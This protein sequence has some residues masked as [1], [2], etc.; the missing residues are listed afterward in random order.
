MKKSLQISLLSL[1][2]LAVGVLFTQ[3]SVTDK[4][5]QYQPRQFDQRTSSGGF[6]YLHSVKANQVTGTID[7]VDV[8]A[9]QNHS[10]LS[11][12]KKGALGLQWSAR[13]PSNIGGR[14]RALLFDKDDA[15]TMFL[16]GVSGGI[17]RSKTGGSSW[18]P[19]HD[20]STN[21]GVTAIAQTSDGTLYYGTGEGMFAGA[22]GAT[23]T[24]TGFV[25]GGIFKSTDGGDTWAAVT[26]TTPTSITTNAEWAS[27][28]TIL[29]HE[30]DANTM[31]VGTN[32][33]I[34]YTT[35]G[36]TSWTNPITVPGGSA[37]ITD[38]HM[39]SQN[40]IW[41]SV[42][43]R[44]FY[45][46]N[47]VTFT[48]I[49]KASAGPTDLPRGQNRVRVETAPTDPNYVYALL[50]GNNGGLDR[51]FKSSDKGA[52]WSVIGQSS[53][54]WDPFQAFNGLVLSGNGQGNYDLAMRVD[55]TNK[56][57]LIIGGIDLWD[58]TSNGSWNV[59]SQWSATPG[60]PWYVHADNHNIYYHPTKTNEFFVVNDGGLFKTSDNGISFVPMNLEFNTMQFYGIGVGADRT[61]IG[62]AQDNGTNINDGTGNNVG[63]AYEIQGGDGGRAAISWLN[64]EVYFAYVNQDLTRTQN[65]ADSWQR[66]GDWFDADMLSSSL[67]WNAPFR[68][69][70]NTSDLNSA[71]S[72]NFIA[73]P[74]LKSLGF[75]NGTIDSFY[76]EMGRPQEAAVFDASSFVVYAGGDTI[77]SDA[78]GNLSGDGTGMFNATTGVFYVIFD[79]APVA[80][81][82]AICN[83]SYASGSDIT[84]SSKIN[85]LPYNYTLMTPLLTGDSVKAQDPVQ[86]FY[87]VCVGG[88]VWMTR[89]ALDFSETPEWW[90]VANIPG[91]TVASIQI[92]DDGDVIYVGTTS[93][94]VI[95]VTNV[96]QAR[97]FETADVTSGTAVTA[98]KNTVVAGNRFVASISAD[99]NDANKVVVTLGNYGN[100]SYVYYSSNAASANPSYASKQGSPT[101]GLLKAPVY[102]SVIHKGDSKKVI[103]GTEFGIYTTDDITAALPI[104]TEENDGFANAPV[105][106][107]VQYR[108]NRSSDTSSTIK[109]GDI[110]IGSHGR[111]WYVSTS[112][113][114]DRP[115]SNEENVIEDKVVRDA[116]KMYPNPAKDFTNVDVTLSGKGDVKASVLDM[117][118]RI[119]KRVSLKGLPQGDHKIRVDLTG[120][121]NGTYV[122]SV[123][124]NG[125]VKNG[126][127]IVNK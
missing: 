80:E 1:S 103:L 58:Y 23:L 87:V 55:K 39:D 28:S 77:R 95:S 31:W 91:Q 62:G 70:E 56:D 113:Q 61:L 43:S 51:V 82:I 57:R 71:D 108:T 107:L 96:S 22:A 12:N 69:H 86:A 20:N 40:G 2:V 72:I 110:Y 53:T 11:T 74:A 125:T 75:G 64:P 126:K 34:K 109:E 124:A 73:Y 32:R 105:W 44:V 29:T 112:L 24:S 119:V 45:S 127:F 46:P 5:A 35:N 41:A 10:G 97:S 66:S 98:V 52:T 8:V 21:V 59:L 54:T 93:G 83:V 67:V 100:Q 99:A 16:G 89:Q 30:T 42:G 3:V 106:D 78:Q 123:S 118:G 85:D 9:A 60:T 19:M 4:Q 13:G 37:S 47:G 121:N 120:I 115:L 48:E 6:E 36:G 101:S 90:K 122:L 102:A 94:R 49:S 104:W 68:L 117:S 88:G 63:S 76:N 27:I 26:S 84:L 7:P 18:I 14:A 116:L 33:G 111:G 79:N 114:T 38:M 17:Y 15:N 65:A 81:I 25:G 50:I 92:S